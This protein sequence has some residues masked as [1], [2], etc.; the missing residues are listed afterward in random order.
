VARSGVADGC[1]PPV[2]RAHDDEWLL[3]QVLVPSVATRLVM[4]SSPEIEEIPAG[5]V[6][7]AVG[8][9]WWCV[10]T[11]THTE[12]ERGGG[13]ES[14]MYFRCNKR[15]TSS[16]LDAPARVVTSAGPG[17]HTG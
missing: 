11:H 8:N 16:L 10:H 7:T 6:L 2:V 17:E 5:T 3:P 13:R 9:A 12:R 1:E 4:P 15:S 14:V